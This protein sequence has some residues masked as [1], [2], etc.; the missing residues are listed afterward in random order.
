MEVAPIERSLQAGEIAGAEDLRQGANR[1]EE[2][3]PSGKPAC[4]IQRERAAGDDAVHGDMLRERLAP[5]VEHGGD[6]EIAAEVARIAAEAGERGGR[7]L[8]Q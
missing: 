2:A 7:G 4:S 8:K 6:A 5:G 3:G 1:E